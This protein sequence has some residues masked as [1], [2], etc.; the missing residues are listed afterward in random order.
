MPRPTILAYYFPDWHS[1]P[2]NTAWFGDGWDEWKLLDGARPRYAG[3]RQPRVPLA[4]HVDESDPAVAA[5]EI[6]LAASHGVDGFLVDYYWYDD[7][8]YLSRALDDGLLRAPNREDVSFALMWANHELVDI[9]PYTDPDAADARRLK[10]G[11]IDRPAFEQMVEH[12][13]AA[14]FR[15]PH[16][17][18][19]DGKPWFSVYEI[20][21]FIAGMGGVDEAR[22]ALDWFRRRVV[23]AGF[24]GLHLDAV[25]WGFGVLP[26]AITVDDPAALL[27][28]LGF[29][30][31]TS[32]VWIH[33][34][35]LGAFSFPEGDAAQL[36]D[37]A[38]ADYEHL[39]RAL[40]VPFHPNV[41]VGWDSTPRI[42]HDVPF[43]PGRYPFLPVF[44]QTPA[45]FERALRR[46]AS[47]VDEHP[48]EHPIITINAWNEWTEG[49]ALLPDVTHRLGFLEALKNVFGPGERRLAA[50]G[51]RGKAAE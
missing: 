9:F 37:A 13:I 50:H 3:H 1:D 45:E 8:P 15:Q 38:F 33:H 23:E 30:N 51:E 10:D 25:V 16:Y 4:G 2:R 22:D 12:I 48:S 47:F 14:Y 39:A 17:L 26:T 36:Q 43:V 35:D 34:A 24:P 46:A 40:P 28:R 44:D 19:I 6:E 29:D 49:S 11:A 32:Y 41:T 27:T 21:N 5:A 31:A 18:T 42:S 20:G 7:G